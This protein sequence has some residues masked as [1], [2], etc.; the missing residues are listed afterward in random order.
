MASPIIQRALVAAL[1]TFTTSV[2]GES[3]LLPLPSAF[4][5]FLYYRFLVAVYNFSDLMYGTAV[6]DKI[7]LLLF[8]SYLLNKEQTIVSIYVNLKIE[9]V[10]AS[11]LPID[12][13]KD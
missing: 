1:G 5:N 8:C 9:A 12:A 6:F 2:R 10:H 11:N 7:I 4:G 13:S 3:P